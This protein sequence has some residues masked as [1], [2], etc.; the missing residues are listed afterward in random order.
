MTLLDGEV[1]DPELDMD[2]ELEEED[3]EEADV[4]ELELNEAREDTDITELELDGSRTLTWG[5]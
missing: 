2:A 1:I 4:A 3:R 5:G